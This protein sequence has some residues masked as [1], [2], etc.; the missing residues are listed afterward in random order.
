MVMPTLFYLG[1][2]IHKEGVNLAEAEKRL[3]FKSL[4][5]AFM[6]Q[7]KHQNLGKVYHGTQHLYSLFLKL[8]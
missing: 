6:S 4:N 8:L 2:L 3:A 5:N 7:K 1:K